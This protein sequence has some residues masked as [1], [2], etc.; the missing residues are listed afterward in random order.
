MCN[1][2]KGH[3]FSLSFLFYLVATEVS[4]VFSKHESHYLNVHKVGTFT[5]HDIFDCTFE[6]LQVASCVSINLAASEG[7]DGK[8]WCEVLSSDKYRNPTSYKG[9]DSSHHYSM[10]VRSRTVFV[11]TL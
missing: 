3:L 2:K 7:L 10:K 8:L 4:H 9:N 1:N 5:V 11:N 6:C